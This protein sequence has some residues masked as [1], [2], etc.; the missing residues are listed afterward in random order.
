MKKNRLWMAAGSVVV[1]AL[2]VWAF[3][4][5]ALEVETAVVSQ[6]RFER[7]VQEDGK[8]RLRD[9]F[10][11]STPLSGRVARIALKRGAYLRDFVH[12]FASLLSDRLD[13]DLIQRA[14]TGHVADYE[15]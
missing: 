6:G 10:V 9:R 12:H 3:S 4:P 1:L 13:K 7:S 2:L 15:L 8:T 14:M 5:S 11:I